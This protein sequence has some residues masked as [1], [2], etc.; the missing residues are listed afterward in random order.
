M[1]TIRLTKII[2]MN[3]RIKDE[4]KDKN[5]KHE[6]KDDEYEDKDDER[7]DNIP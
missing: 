7:K 6:D 5:D 3:T 1:V 4:H 2:I